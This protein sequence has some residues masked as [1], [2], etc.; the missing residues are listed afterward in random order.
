MTSCQNCR[1]GVSSGLFLAAVLNFLVIAFCIYVLVQ[2]FEK[3]KR[4]I[5]RQEALAE[6]AP[7]ATPV[8]QEKLTGAIEQ[9][10]Y[11]IETRS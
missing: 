2:A 1:L 6:E 5:T 9:L 7:D 11:T 10:T 4:R 3:A 8:A